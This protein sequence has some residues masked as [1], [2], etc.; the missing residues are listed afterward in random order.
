MPGFNAFKTRVD[1][2]THP[3]VDAGNSILVLDLVVDASHSWAGL[4][5]VSA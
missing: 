4:D 5:T 1:F 3:A 2:G